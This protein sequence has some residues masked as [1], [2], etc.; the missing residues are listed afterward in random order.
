M[1][2][3]RDA[4]LALGA[5]AAGAMLAVSCSAA[6]AAAAEPEP[7]QQTRSVGQPAA[8][9]VGVASDPSV[10]S[11]PKQRMALAKLRD[12]AVSPE[13]TAAAAHDFVQVTANPLDINAVVRQVIAP[14]AGGVSVFIG[15]TRDNFNGKIVERLEYEAFESMA[16]KEMRKVAAAMRSQWTGNGGLVAICI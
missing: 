5:A 7:V 8:N 11:T 13:A 15:T 6:P 4:A 9:I 1:S 2:A 12:A 16:V 3:S 14:G 10:E